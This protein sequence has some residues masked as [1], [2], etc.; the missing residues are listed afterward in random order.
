ME[1]LK[2]NVAVVTGVGRP[3]GIGA[4]ICRSLAREGVDVFFT[5]WREYDLEQYPNTEDPERLLAL[6]RTFD[7]KAESAEVDLR[8]PDAARKLFAR[9]TE[10]LGPATILIN[11]A[12]IDRSIAFEQ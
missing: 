10:A 2:G 6:L 4:T 11:N 9:A 12:C 7:V 1:S 3:E 5:Y 8:H